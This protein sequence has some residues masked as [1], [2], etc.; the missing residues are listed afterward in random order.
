M[1]SHSPWL[2]QEVVWGLR[3]RPS[4]LQELHC[5]LLL[6]LSFRGLS[7]GREGRTQSC[8]QQGGFMGPLPLTPK[9][10]WLVSELRG[11]PP[12]QTL[13]A[14]KKRKHPP[15]SEFQLHRHRSRAGEEHP[16]G[17]ALLPLTLRGV[18]CQARRRPSHPHQVRIRGPLPVS[19]SG[20]S[21][22]QKSLDTSPTAPFLSSD[23]QK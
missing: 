2:L 1:K 22:W 5:P 11:A 3:P 6:V 8:E 23:K 15:Q 4:T 21:V 12:V 17:R 16:L 14:Q 10:V 7:R 18:L 19:N 20:V 9:T 13:K